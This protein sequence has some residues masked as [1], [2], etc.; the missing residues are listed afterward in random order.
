[1]SA[2]PS[3]LSVP[4][5][6][7]LPRVLKVDALTCVAMGLLL[8]AAHSTLSPLLGLPAALLQYA[9]LLLFPCAALMAWAGRSARP[10]SA[11]VW[12]VILG[13]LA[14]VLASLL[15]AFVWFSPTV[16]GQAFLVVQALAV[17]GLAELEYVGLRRTRQRGH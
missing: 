5:G 16:P 15:L 11:L 13:N 9:G 12:L 14:W 7:L 6:A 8:V 10:A 1:M 17:L 4:S 2:I 3:S